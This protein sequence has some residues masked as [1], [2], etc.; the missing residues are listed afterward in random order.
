MNLLCIK[1]YDFFMQIKLY[2]LFIN[3]FL[4]VQ[5]CS[6]TFCN[7][8]SSYAID[9]CWLDKNDSHNN[10]NEFNNEYYLE[11]V[12]IEHIIFH[13]LWMLFFN[14]VHLKFNFHSTFFSVISIKF[15][16]K[17]DKTF[18]KDEVNVT[19]IG[20][21]E[22]PST[23]NMLATLL[24]SMTAAIVLAELFWSS[25]QCHNSLRGLPRR[26]MM[27]GSTPRLHTCSLTNDCFYYRV[28]VVIIIG[29]LYIFF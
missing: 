10:I 24:L 2:Y 27:V 6:A 9:F 16:P 17:M 29:L 28:H 3:T 14:F 22:I 18:S 26:E 7:I 19:Q 20:H 4:H 5:W 15:I 21:Q 11:T 25:R 1:R 23:V 13:M 8:M 12:S